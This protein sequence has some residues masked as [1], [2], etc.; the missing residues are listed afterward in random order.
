[1]DQPENIDRQ[2]LMLFRSHPLIAPL[3]QDERWT[4]STWVDD[5]DTDDGKKRKIP[6]DIRAVLEH[7][8]A[9]GAKKPYSETCLT[10]DKLL[11]SFTTLPNV[12]FFL[13]AHIDGIIVLDIEPRCPPETTLALLRIPGAIHQELSMS[14]CGYHI[15]FP[16]PPNFQAYPE[17]AK[18]RVICPG[19]TFEILVEHWVTFT[20]RPIPSDRFADVNPA[21]NAPTTL[22]ELWTQ[23]AEA[24]SRRQ[25]ASSVGLTAEIAWPRDDPMSPYAEAV[26]GDAVRNATPRMKTPQDF[27]GDLSRWEFSVL[28]TLYGALQTVITRYQAFGVACPPSSQ[29]RLLHLAAISV[30]PHR[31]KHNELRNGQPYLF[32]RARAIVDARLASKSQTTT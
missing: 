28:A 16:L 17:A 5:P 9:R 21:P 12:A 4:V 2:A 15:V 30:L 26:V 22:E 1:M 19:D 6:L 7:S 10:L 18:K 8:V 24:D 11:S 23:M 25:T 31:L 27:R 14:G 3:T 32:E 13:K 20:A 29:V